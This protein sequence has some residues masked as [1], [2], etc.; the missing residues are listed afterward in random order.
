M[1]FQLCP[2]GSRKPFAQCCQPL[3]EGGAP[4]LTPAAL[5]RSRYTA[6]CR[7]NID[8]LIATHHPSKRQPDD[9]RTLQNSVTSTEWLSLMVLSAPP[10]GPAESV[11]LVEFAAFYKKHGEFRQL[12]ER[13]QFIKENGRW[14][15]LQGE[16]LPPVILQRNDPCW[17]G[18]GKKY[19]RCHGR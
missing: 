7:G 14:F 12:H 10:P 18:S 1:S 15:Y 6:F 3:I 19:K 13:S 5:M 9:R 17:C 4:A 2:C 16:I 11:G 8:Y